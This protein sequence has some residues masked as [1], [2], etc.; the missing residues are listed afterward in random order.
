MT[1]YH[2]DVAVIGSG[3][4]G[5]VVARRLQDAGH[6]VTIL[7][8]GPRIDPYG[9][10]KQT[11]D[12]KYLLQ[13][14][15]SVDSDH[16]SLTY[17]EALGG[18]SGFYELVS[19]RTP[20][21]VFDQRDTRT[22][23]RLWPRGIDRS[24]M[25][26]FYEIAEAEVNASVAEPERLPRCSH[27]FR[28]LLQRAGLTATDVKHAERG[29]IGSG[30][31]ITGCIYGAKQSMLVTHLPAAEE[32]GATI[33]T[34][35]E[36]LYLQRSVEAPYRYEVLCRDRVQKTLFSVH[37][38]AVVL[39]AGVVGSAAVLLRSTTHLPR[40]SKQV[41]RNIASNGMV[42]AMGLIPDDL[43]DMDMY[44]GRAHSGLV[45][46]DFFEE[47]GVNISAINTLPLYMA[48]K[49]HISSDSTRGRYWGAD[50]LALMQKISR[51]GL[52]L[53]ATGM[54]PGYGRLSV[55]S[56]GSVSIDAGDA[57]GYQA[58]IDRVRRVLADLYRRMGCTPLQIDPIDGSGV[59]YGGPHIGTTHQ[60][61]SCRMAESIEQ[62]VCD[63][64]GEVFNY[65]GIFVADSSALPTSLTVNPSLTIMANAE[66]IAP[67]VKEYLS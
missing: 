16:L 22:A 65:Q 40:L 25:D 3:F 60:T 38:R 55:G 51:R 17:A 27:V 8:K 11:Q 9:D 24:V 32:A 48:S 1:T 49:A 6:H 2:T 33:R 21:P 7:E 63:V 14:L 41:G 44:S 23:A 12:P 4:G 29:C 52:I 53:Y 66:R 58:Y 47:H 18:G 39:G 61:G 42:Q 26:P 28:A 64:R 34:D 45:C 30:Y 54:I 5:S 46:T 50:H 43:P 59:E 36:V 20:A 15:R 10:F 57:S 35:C 56:N 37:C 13:F 19:L 67:Y 31:C 62:G